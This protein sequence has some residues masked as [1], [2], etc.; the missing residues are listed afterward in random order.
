M[1]GA[2]VVEREASDRELSEV[3][4]DVVVAM[5]AVYSYP[6]ERLAPISEALRD[7][8]LFEPRRLAT[9]SIQELTR[10]L[11]AAGYDR[12]ALTWQYADRLISLG[13]YLVEAGCE[14]VGHELATG[15]AAVAEKLLLPVHGIGP[16]VIENFVALRS[17][18]AGPFAAGSGR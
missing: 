1:S 10:E 6:L 5:L 3:W 4:E 17:R 14:R 11:K 9:A 16:K 18:R 2:M 7:A 8:G 15:D 12:G 13:K